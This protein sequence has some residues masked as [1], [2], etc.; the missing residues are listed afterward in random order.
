MK[1]LIALFLLLLSSGFALSQTVTTSPL[2]SPRCQF[3][4]S[5]GAPLAGGKVYTYSAGSSNPL[6]TY[7][8]SGS[9]PGGQVQNSNPIILDAGGFADIWTAAGSYKVVVT[10]YAGVQQYTVDYLGVPPATGDSSYLKADGSNL[11][12]KSNIAITGQ[13]GTANASTNYSSYTVELD[14]SYW[15]STAA[16]KDS[17]I[18]QDVLGTGA[19]PTSTLNLSHSGSSGSA[20]LG[21]N[22]DTLTAWPRG[23]WTASAS[24]ANASSVKIIAFANARV[25]NFIPDKAITIARVQVVTVFGPTGCTTQG[26]IVV[27]DGITAASTIT[28][29]NGTS[30]YDS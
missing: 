16:A 23:V 8:N 6:T 22:G 12:F 24:A 26:G 11:P 28:F 4:D 19:N 27:S 1:T 2:C 13:Q 17:W 21:L 5:N 20:K 18:L 15:N 9:D 7:K 14:A 3:F 29:A 25:S 10:D 30:T